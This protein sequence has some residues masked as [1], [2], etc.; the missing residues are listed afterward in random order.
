[1]EAVHKN[2]LEFMANQNHF[3]IPKYQR[4]YAWDKRQ[5]ERLFNDISNIYHNK[6]ETYFL[7]AS[8]VVVSERP[9]ELILIDGQ[10]RLTSISL[11]MLAICNL[12]KQKKIKSNDPYLHETIWEDYLI[13]KRK[14]KSPQWIRLKQVNQDST[15]YANLFYD[16]NDLGYDQDKTLKQTAIYENYQLF[17]K[18]VLDFCK[19]HS[20]D[21][22]WASFQKLQIVQ[23]VLKIKDGDKPQIVFETINSTGKR[24]KDADLIRNY[25]LMDRSQELQD[26]WFDEY[27]ETIETNTLFIGK[28]QISDTTTAILYY[29]IYKNQVL[30]K[31]KDV[32]SYFRKYI[33]NLSKQPDSETLQKTEIENIEDCLSELIDFTEYYR[34]FVLECPEPKL[35]KYFSIFRTLNQKTPYPYFMALMDLVYKK[36]TLDLNDAVRILDFLKNYYIRRS[37]ISLSTNAYNKL[38]SSL[39]KRV[40][41]KLESNNSYIT[42]LYAVF[43]NAS[44]GERYPDNDEIVKELHDKPVYKGSKKLC[45]H[46][47]ENL[48]N[49]GN[50]EKIEVN[51]DITIEHIM[52]QTLNAQWIKDLGENAGDIHEKYLDTIGN[53]T[54]TGYNSKHSNKP[55]T[56]KKQLMKKYSNISLNKHFEQ[57]DIWNE[58]QIKIRAKDMT[59]LFN[60]VFPDIP[61]RKEYKNQDTGYIGLSDF[62]PT[63]TKP[64]LYKLFGDVYKLKYKNWRCLLQSVLKNLYERDDEILLDYKDINKNLSDEKSMLREPLEITSNLYV[65]S[66]QSAIDISK[67]LQN[68][69]VEYECTEE[70][71]VKLLRDPS[72]AL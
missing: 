65:E 67:I 23:I 32:Y 5:C 17:N 6:L 40:N 52:P 47:L 45:K 15:A 9:N 3:I 68:I 31:E 33:D 59:S 7:G 28:K 38:Y 56:D 57:V 11:L 50:N 66:N 30:L 39:H 58:E 48:C 37:V 2:L 14:E 54:L 41:E 10:Q 36:Q 44:H 8:V 26:R 49:Y 18:K 61:N 62:D 51:K 72:N 1:M 46:I 34:W 64:E 42:S 13:N 27:W 16:E 60:Q 4:N 12:L 55:F 20:I 19:K 63:G 21:D 24:L 35:E 43:A 25:I 53:L 70:F 71:K 69:L 22:F 29:L